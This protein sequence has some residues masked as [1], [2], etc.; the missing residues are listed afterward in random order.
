MKFILKL[1]VISAVFFSQLSTVTAN[2]PIAT[3]SDATPTDRKAAIFALTR[4]PKIDQRHVK[5]LEDLIASRVA[6]SGFQTLTRE[7]IVDSLSI[8]MKNS[9]AVDPQNNHETFASELVD[10]WKGTGQIEDNIEKKLDEQSSMMRLAQIIGADLIVVA[11]AES[12][13]T[14]KIVFKGNGLAPVA[15]TT[16]RNE[17]RVSYRLA[18]ASSGGAVAG[19]SIKISRAWR[20]SENLHRETDDLLNG[21]FDEVSVRLAGKIIESNQ[22]VKEVPD[23]QVAEVMFNTKALLPGGVPLQLPVYQNGDVN[24]PV[25]ANIAADVI[26]DG[27]SLGSVPGSLNVVTGLH[28]IVVQAEGFKP[29]KRFINVSS[30]QKFDVM[31]EMTP[32]GYEKWKE[33]ITFLSELSQKTKLTDAEVKQMEAKSEAMRKAGLIITVGGNDLEMIRKK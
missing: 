21:M 19:D 33:I 11:V 20:E 24:M 12:Y 26:V 16:I 5:I 18:F 10:S 15:T 32:Q 3:Q 13:G 30:G 4:D 17:L 27:V 28:Q 25:S 23:L 9:V 2:T 7:M 8:S 6:N 1:L 22:A 14:E 31:L 29:W